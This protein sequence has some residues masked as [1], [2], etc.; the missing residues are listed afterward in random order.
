MQKRRIVFYAALLATTLATAQNK[1]N[2]TSTDGSVSSYNTTEVNSIGISGN[3]VTVNPQGASF[4]ASRIN[5]TKVAAGAVQIKESNG[6]QES[7]YVTW[8]LLSGAESYKVYVKGG[9]YSDYTKLDDQLVRNYG[10]YGRADAVGLTAGTYSLKVVPVIGGKEDESKASE[11]TSLTV[12]NYNREGFAHKDATAGIGAYNNDGSL[13][14]GAVVIYVTAK[15]AK[16]VSATLANGTFTGIQAIL[17]AYQKK[18][19]SQPPLDIRVVGTI[20]NGETDAFGSSS[21]GLQIKGATKDTPLNIT[22]EG[23]GNDATIHGFGFLVRNA[24]YI[25]FRNLGIMRQMD[26]GISLD[27]DNSHIWIHNIDVFYGKQGSGDHAKGDGGI[28]VKSDSKYVTID[29]CHF[30]DT[31]KSSMCGMKSESG[32]NYITYHHNWFDHSDSRHPRIR[33][34]SVHVYNNYFDGV[35]KY[36]IGAASS[37]DVFSEA[38]Y[39]RATEYPMTIASQAHDIKAD[40]SSV[41]SGEDGGII[42][43]YN[44]II[45]DLP[46]K[47]GFTPWSENNT[48]FDAY[49]VSSR[50]EKVPSSVTAQKGGHSYSNFDTDAS[51]MYSYTPDAAADVPSKVTG[52]L[53]AGRINHGDAQYKFTNSTDDSGY[54]PISALASLIDNYKSSL[55]GIFGDE[56]AQSGEQGSDDKGGSTGGGDQG[57]TGGEAGGDTGG[58]TGGTVDQP[59]GTVVISFEGKKPSNDIVTVTGSYSTSKGT[60]TYGGVTYSTC[61]KMESKTNIVVNAT[62]AYKMTLVFGDSETASAKIDGTKISGSGSTYTQDIS[63]KTTITKANSVNLFAIVLAP[64]E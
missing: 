52:F 11:A 55:V 54:T 33:T 27:T 18:G 64:A 60:A 45:V 32:P 63:G 6:W 39:F 8:N 21:E 50:D 34:M 49:V 38:N 23:I 40:G 5:F 26:D 57:Q 7:A 20:N 2:I 4:T 29:N 53:G 43:A 59:T 13:K 31:G 12:T 30:W 37:S 48:N 51:V 44:N 47:G 17:T 42:K 46:S 9:K 56:N 62:K 28:D 16:T 36:G 10:T 35:A 3:T 25:E 22:I 24:G 41:L 58:D 61:V 19:V 14:S 15:N 1:V